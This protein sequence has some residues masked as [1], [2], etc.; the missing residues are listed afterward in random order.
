MA[1][2][3]PDFIAEFARRRF[4]AKRRV[5]TEL[6]DLLPADHTVFTLTGSGDGH[7]VDFII[8]TPWGL[9]FMNVAG[10]T[11]DVLAPPQAGAE[12]THRGPDGY[13]IGAIRPDRLRESAQ[14]IGRRLLAALP[15]E[16]R[17]RPEDFGCGELHVL[18]DTLAAHAPGVDM[19][20]P[21]RQVLVS[22]DLGRIAEWVER[23]AK[24]RPAS[25]DLTQEARHHLTEALTG[26]A[27]S[28]RPSPAT[29]CLGL[30]WRHAVM[31][32]G[33]GAVLTMALLAGDFRKSTAAINSTAAGPGR[34]GLAMP[35]FVPQ[36]AE[37]AVLGAIE[38]AVESPGRPVKWRHGETGG[39]VT[40][41]PGDGGKC[42]TFR[43]S[44]GQPDPSAT[45]DRRLC[46]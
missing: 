28:A 40:L 15:A 43:I 31:A 1:V 44:Q 4:E 10:G 13:F 11:V 17:R 25:P 33:A 3:V 30:R 6:R 8:L 22:S 45:T 23:A 24:A 26:Q 35:G 29:L 37:W 42:R 21:Q 34:T 14:S 18:P 9:V 27:R 2:M 41:L 39:T 36:G 7:L 20:S 19:A 12:W 38:V 46:L 16:Y 32:A 5:W